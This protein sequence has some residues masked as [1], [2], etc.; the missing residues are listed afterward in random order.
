MKRPFNIF[1]SIGY[2]N[3][4]FQV[5]SKTENLKIEFFYKGELEKEILTSSESVFLIQ[6]LEKSG[7]YK[8]ICTSKGKTFEQEIKVVDAFRLGSSEFKKSF[9]FDNSDYSFFLMKDRLLLYDEEKNIILTENLYS[10]TKIIQ[11][12]KTNYLFITELGSKSDGIINFGVY[13][14]DSFSIIGELLNDYQTIKISPETNRLWLYKKSTESIH[15]FELTNSCGQVLSEIR[16][17]DTVLKYWYDSVSGKLTMEQCDKIIFIDVLKQKRST[18]IPKTSKNAIDKNGNNLILNA[19]TVQ[20]TNMLNEYYTSINYTENFNLNFTDF[21]YIGSDYPKPTQ[22]SDLTELCMKIK[23]D[24]IDSFPLDDNFYSYSLPYKAKHIESIIQHNFYATTKGHYLIKK[25]TKRIV[26]KVYFKKIDKEWIAKPKTTESNIFS[27][28]YNDGMI[29]KTIIEPTY[30]FKFEKYFH[31]L[32]IILTDNKKHIYK[33]NKTIS[34]TPQ[35]TLNFHLL[36]DRGYL[37]V[38]EK[39][40]QSV[41]D[42]SNLHYP[43]LNDIKIHNI[44]L[45]DQHKIIW[46][47]GKEKSNM[48]LSFLN[49]YDL[50]G[51]SNIELDEN[52]AQ[53]SWFKSSTDYKYNK[54]FILSSNKIIINPKTTDIKGSYIGSIEAYSD[55]LKKIVSQRYNHIYLSIYNSNNKKY[56][57]QEIKLSSI[58]FKESYLSPNGQFLVLQDDKNKYIWYDIENNETVRFFSGNFLSFSKEGNLIIEEDGTRAVKIYD[59]LTFS[60]IT[61]PNYHHYRFLSPDGKLYAQVSKKTRYLDNLSGDELSIDDV[62]KLRHELDEPSIFH[63]I[64]NEKKQ[65]FEKAKTRINRNRKAYF[66]ANKSILDKIDIKE[67]NTITSDTIVKVE[68][69]TEIGIVGTNITTEI[70]L[71]EELDYYNYAAFS[72]DNNYFGYAGKPSS[73]GLICIFKIDF[74]KQNEKLMIVDTYLSYYPRYATWVCGFSKTGYFATYDSTPDTYLIKVDEQLFKTKADKT[75]FSDSIDQEESSMHNF[76]P[77][78]NEIK[79]KNF[80]CFSPTG[81]FMALSEQGYEP[82]TLG[83]YG[84]QESNAVHISLTESMKIV[85]SFTGH[86]DKIKHDN[87]KNITF[88]GFSE[89]EKRIMSLSS[90]GVVIIRGL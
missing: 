80:L 68:K 38:K 11:I 40:L 73:G 90:D 20:C 30:Q 54:G 10:P 18:V 58:S 37:I 66:L 45:I 64:N 85:N 19:D 48:N 17:Y 23:N 41:Y 6:K 42:T 63:P 62:V 34:F 52:K 57:K 44:D 65:E 88:V 35:C 71:P 16:K 7:T 89:D 82:L 5:L 84:H 53:H 3:S 9:V 14:T 29:S 21:L 26:N 32:L 56:E 31:D 69:F 50:S 25:E 43:I 2:K 33:D 13:S 22:F 77:Q 74:N 55:G 79:G 24:V 87:T 70:L 81:N 75:T 46:Y 76:F 72:Y 47:S 39:D 83:G 28:I 61:P 51:K 67:H 59:P 86:G 60:E 12:D 15:C 27:L 36:N 49:A 4:Q 8:A 1:P 78:W